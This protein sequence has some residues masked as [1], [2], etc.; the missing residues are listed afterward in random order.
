MASPMPNQEVTTVADTFMK[1]LPFRV[2]KQVLTNQRVQF[3]SLVFT[4]VCNML[5]VQQLFTTAFRPQR[6]TQTKPMNSA[7][8]AKLSKIVDQKV[9][10]RMNCCP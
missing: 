2:Q 7:L 5:G 4:V 3:T 6:D 9:L 8:I 1:V 10:T